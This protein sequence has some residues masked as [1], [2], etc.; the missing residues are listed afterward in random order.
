MLK[1]SDKHF[2]VIEYEKISKNEI[3]NKYFKELEDIAQTTQILAYSKKG[4][5]KSQNYVGIIQTKSG[6]VLEIL[7]KISVNNDYEESK[8]ILIEMIKTLKNHPFRK[9]STAN[10]RTEKMLL[11]EIFISFFLN[12]LDKLIKKGIKRD[13]ISWL[14]NQKFLKGKLLINEHIK[15]NFIHKERFFVEY[16]EYT[17]DILENR[18]IKSTLKKLNKLSKSFENQKR[19]R[20]FLFV[21]ESVGEIKSLGELKKIHIDRSKK[22]YENIIEICKIFLDNKSYTPYKGGSVS[23]AVLF[24]MNKLFESFVGGCFK[25]FSKGVKLQHKKFHLFDVEKKYGLIPDMVFE[26]KIFDTKWKIIKSLEDVSGSDF[27]QMFAYAKKYDSK[28]VTLIY[29]KVY[30]TEEKE[31]GFEEEYKLKVVFFDLRKCKKEISRILN[32]RG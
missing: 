23:F 21:F 12:E 31:L 1:L 17:G 25:K 15:R 30:D 7:P 26:N 8:K 19:I 27:Y 29:P 20:K 14:D 28:E 24:D 2:Q 13:Y 18:V 3:N 10:L 22:Y 9:L 16:D 6:F 11:L 32:E 5:L 4:V